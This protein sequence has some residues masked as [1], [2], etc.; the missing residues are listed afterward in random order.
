MQ[1]QRLAWWST[2]SLIGVLCVLP[3]AAGGALCPGDCNGDGSVTVEELVRAVNVGLGTLPYSVCG[4][5]DGDGNEEVTIDELITAV[6]SALESCP[7]T[8]E[9]YR[10]PAMSEP[11]GPLGGGKAILPNGRRVEPAGVQVA[12][13]TLPLNLQL[14]PDEQH[15]VITND[16]H[17]DEHGNQFLQLLD[18]QTLAV[19][20]T[21]VPQFLGLAMNP[22]GDRLFVAA[23]STD[24]PDLVLALRIT[25]NELV[26][27]QD[28]V[29]TLPS[30]IFPTGMAASPDGSH[31]YLAGLRSNA[32]YAIDLVSGAVHEA[33]AKVG[34]YPYGALVSPDGSRAYVSSW[35]INNGVPSSPVPPPLPALDPNESRRSSVAIVDLTDPNAPQVVRS[36]PIGRTLALN[37][38]TVFGGSHPSA[39]AL[40]PDQQLLYVTATN[41]DLLSVVDTATSG[42]VTEMPLNVF[43]SGPTDRHLQGLYPNAIAVSPD[44][45]RLY[46][47]DAGINAV[48]VIAVDQQAR[49]FTHVGF[50]PVG[51]YPSALALSRDGHRLFVANGKGDSVGPNGGPDFDE[52]ESGTSYIGEILKGSVSV[53]DAVD[54]YDLAT[55]QSQV[56]ALNGLS[57]V[58]VRWVDGEPGAGEVQR[59]NPVPIDFGSGPSDQIKYVVFILKENRTYD[60]VFG[61][62]PSGNGDPSLLMYGDE[63]T[64]NAHALAAQFA[65][66]D[67]FFNDGEISTSGHEWADQANCNDWIEKLWPSNY[68]RT[69]PSA[70]LEQGQEGFAKAGFFFQALEQ[71]HVS[72]RVYG[73]TLGLL[74]RFASGINGQGVGSLFGPL[75]QAFHGVPTVDQLYTIINGDIESLRP[76]GV[77]VDLVRQQIFPDQALDFPSNLISTF[78]DVHRAQ[79][80]SAE[81][82]GFTAAGELPQFIHIWLPNDHTFGG[83]PGEPSPRSYVADNDAGLGMIVDALSHSP[84]WS[85]MAIF[86]T[87]DDPQ[88][89][90]DHVAAHRTISLVISPY[91]KH[92]YVSHVHHSSVSMNK[93][94]ELLLGVTPLGE[95]DRY[96]TDMRD[97]FTPAPD[98]AP[99]VARPR[100]V[101]EE[102]NP[103]AAAAPNAYLRRAAELSATL[104]LSAADEAGERMA[105]ILRLIHIGEGVEWKKRWVLRIALMSAALLGAA[106][107]LARRPTS[108][109]RA[110]AA[111]T[112]ETAEP[113]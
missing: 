4:P 78:S 83:R 33:N 74:S 30:G 49:T 7:A 92:G 2:A 53:I 35:G 29:A 58:A 109:Y 26:R 62:V 8:T 91:T 34:N 27:E 110:A 68:D 40:S 70:V 65:M 16:G 36:V 111:G 17:G 39:M 98:F 85:Q 66:G 93:T 81:L 45:R 75:V 6:R 112:R 76:T 86:V 50:I 106:V 48:Q 80:F 47:A 59:G 23:D 104:N 72:H 13:E 31:L 21:A 32:L 90:Q 46:I 61:D 28:I 82:D 19:T 51:W 55:G 41:V 38:R 107:H 5:A 18:T 44:G 88:D 87:E 56:M 12:V 69:L 60:Q 57:P 95:F 54:Q 71:Q 101:P 108:R 11:S 94:M 113:D 64:P 9:I 67:N 15:L 37:N 22:Q 79:I 14:T 84:F 96:A 97:Y 24:D 20:K 100:Q 42:V 3:L 10:A 63:V 103:T 1:T 43:E 105:E 77:N 102:I 99:Y 73:E 52:T 25:G 89:G